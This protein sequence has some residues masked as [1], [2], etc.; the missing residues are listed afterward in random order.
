MFH[1]RYFILSGI[2]VVAMEVLAAQK[3]LLFWYLCQFHGVL[4]FFFKYLELLAEICKFCSNE[5]ETYWMQ[6]ATVY[7]GCWNACRLLFVLW[8]VLPPRV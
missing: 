5:L 3:T 6:N 8:I 1:L 4:Y 7:Y 2:N